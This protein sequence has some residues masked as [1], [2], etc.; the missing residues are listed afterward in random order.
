MRFFTDFYRPEDLNRTPHFLMQ[1]EFLLRLRPKSAFIIYQKTYPA[2]T[3]MCLLIATYRFLLF[4]LHGILQRQQLRYQIFLVEQDDKDI[5]NKAQLMN[6]AFSY[7]VNNSTNNF[8][9]FIFH[10]VDLLSEDDRTMYKCS[11]L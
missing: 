11:G 9:C 5:F 6:T 8:N 10:D 4:H 3:K 2:K 1:D 7:V